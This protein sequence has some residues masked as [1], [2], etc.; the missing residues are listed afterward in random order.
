MSYRINKTDGSLLLDLIDGRVD[1]ITTDLSLIGRNFSGYGELFNTNF[2]KLLENFAASSPPSRPLVGQLW[3]DTSEGRLKIWSGTQFRSTDTTIVSNVEPDLLS[4]DIWIDSRNRQ[5]FF[6]DG[7]GLQLAGPV[8]TRDQGPTGFKVETINDRFGNPKT[9]AKIIV[10]STE[11]ALISR[12]SFETT[13]PLSG[14]G[15]QIQEG[16]VVNSNRPNFEFRGTVTR[17]RQLVDANGDTFDPGA[18]LTNNTNNVT[19]GTLHINNDSGLRVGRDVSFVIRNTLGPLTAIQEV[20]N[21]NAN[22]RLL[23]STDGIPTDAIFINTEQKHLGIW[24]NNP[25]ASLDVDGD[26]KISGNLTVMGD[27]TTVETANLRVED[28]NIELNFSNSPTMPDDIAADGGGITLLS[29]D[30]NKTFQWELTSN[31]WTSN[32]NIDLESGNVYKISGNNI[33]SETEL[34]N[35]TRAASLTEVGLLNDLSV[36]NFVFSNSTMEV[37]GTLTIDTQNDI[38]VLNDRRISG[39]GLPTNNQDVATKAYVDQEI[40]QEPV[41]L[42]VDVTGVTSNVNAYI[43]NIL[44][45]MLPW[46][47]TENVPSG[48][49]VANPFRKSFGTRAIIHVVSRTATVSINPTAQTTKNVVSVDSDGVQNQAVIQDFTFADQDYN[50]SFELNPTL[51]KT[52]EFQS[53]S[54]GGEWQFLFDGVQYIP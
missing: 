27:T 46:T 10:N 21:V 2:V 53:S 35:V 51:F 32:V 50:I 43:K 26:M 1:N 34:F 22:Y 23:V 11:L 8:Y 37:S 16:I 4:G 41:Y 49:Q 18:V 47:T 38:L 9:V 20:Q 7:T 12:D 24:N 54:S 13:I 25:A 36:A 31:S 39:V 6:N 45:N 44:D 30:G 40:Q 14:Y 42:E 19:S 28:K 3:Y 29:D 17:A 52:F 48:S 5:L 33:L 15:T